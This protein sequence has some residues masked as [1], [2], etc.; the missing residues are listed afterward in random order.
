MDRVGITEAGE[1]AF[2]LDVF[3]RLEKAN[4]IITKRLSLGVIDRLIKN[5]EKIILHLD[6]TGYGKTIVEPF[7][8]PVSDTVESF[9]ILIDH[10]FP[11]DHIVLRIDPVIPTEKGIGVARRVIESFSGSGIKR[12]R[13]SVLDMYSHV[14][15]RFNKAGFPIP[16]IT[17]HAPFEIRKEIY[18]LFKSYTEFEIETC[19]EPGFPST[20]CLSQKDLD[21]LGVNIKLEG[22]AEQRKT[23]GCPANKKELIVGKP[24]RCQHNCTYCFWKDETL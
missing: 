18:D 23:C 20:P 3:D 16:F 17:F 19:A 21:I 13:F 24:H 5:K 2:N 11:I 8:P 15:E 4:I 22:S 1:V 6:C 12:L 9:K 14:K 10:G 7:V